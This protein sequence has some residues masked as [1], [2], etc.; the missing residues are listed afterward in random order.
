MA[1]FLKTLV[2]CLA[3]VH[4]SEARE[5]HVGNSWQIPSSPDAFDKWAQKNRFEIGDS[6]V[7]KY[8]GKKDSVVEVNEADYRSCIKANPIKTYNDGNTKITLE[9][10]GLFFF[11]S[12]AEGHCEKGQK[13]EVRVLSANHHPHSTVAPA[14]SPVAHHHHAPAPAPH[15]GGAT[16]QFGVLGGVAAAL[17]I[18][19]V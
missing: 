14:P 16:L 8:D 6:I 13:L 7:L 11:I 9:K 19:L 17:V 4:L 15:N 10:S 12:G 5:F 18:A 1:A 3:L 2:L